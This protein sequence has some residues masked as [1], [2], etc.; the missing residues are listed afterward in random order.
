MSKGKSVL[1]MAIIP[2]LLATA[3]GRENNQAGPEINPAR[4]YFRLVAARRLRPPDFLLMREI[5]QEELSDYIKTVDRASALSLQ[6][7]IETAL[8][9][10]ERGIVPFA[11]AQTAEK[12]IQYA[13]YLDL[14]GAMDSLSPAGGN[15]SALTR[16]DAAGPV[17]R[18]TAERR[19]RWLGRGEEL[20]GIFDS[21]LA[22]IAAAPRTGDQASLRA[23]RSE[24]DDFLAAI[25]VLS[26]LY[27][28]EG[29]EKARGSDPVVTAEK[30]AEAGIFYL[31][32]RERHRQSSAGAARSVEEMIAHL[33]HQ[34]D[35]ELVESIL[36]Q[37]FARELS[38]LSL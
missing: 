2:V 8:Q 1:S 4:A 12:L 29:L 6:N 9:S 7:R 16:I 3:C 20:G 11:N 30:L 5:Y 18:A 35:I 28:L 17:I 33:S 21:L 27:E 19:S 25:Y 13:F 24:M 37:D 26:V 31:F 23:A 36:K 15:S 22:G 34:I 38:A 32:I 14:L 10:G